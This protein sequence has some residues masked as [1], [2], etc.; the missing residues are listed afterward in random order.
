MDS[1]TT[2]LVQQLR[3]ID[4]PSNNDTRVQILTAAQALCHRLETPFEWV[5][6]MTWQ[7]VSNLALSLP[8]YHSNGRIS[9]Q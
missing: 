2:R 8:L 4:R 3:S 1:E 7:E 9:L 6:R 5:Q